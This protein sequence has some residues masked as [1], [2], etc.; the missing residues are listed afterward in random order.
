MIENTEG[1]EIVRALYRPDRI[2]TL[3][4]GESPPHS[5]DFFYRGDSAMRLHYASTIEL[6]LGESKDFLKS[7]KSYGWYLD[8]LVL[9]P[10][11]HL[12]PRER[13]E[14]C[15]GA[16]KCLADRVAVCRP[17][18]IVSVLKSIEPFVGAAAIMAG[19][20]APRYAVPFPLWGQLRRFQAEM[21]D[22][23]PKLP[24]LTE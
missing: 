7:F 10:V 5:G 3:F 23:I 13:K 19:C 17:E 24:R 18:A 11:N 8:D 14:K 2:K 15:L 9:E 12:P 1:V 4:V 22:L 16:Q 6:A 20:D 21:A